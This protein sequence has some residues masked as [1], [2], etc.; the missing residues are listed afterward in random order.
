MCKSLLFYWAPHCLTNNTKCAGPCSGIKKN[1]SRLFFLPCLLLLFTP[2]TF[3][4]TITE[5]SP[6]DFGTI[7]I[8]DN[9]AAYTHRV[10]YTGQIINDPEI[11]IIT[12]GSPAEYLITGLPV[13]TLLAINVTSPSGVTTSPA[14]GPSNEQFT[15]SNFDYLPSVTSN[16][17]GE[18][19]LFVGATLTT[20]GANTYQDTLYVTTMTITITY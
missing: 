13:S 18:Y 6:L 8:K 12:P 2:P 7:A 3:A 20:S 10:R 1:K 19:T 15:I 9:S 17:I 11:I 14:T 5:L 16:A 4:E